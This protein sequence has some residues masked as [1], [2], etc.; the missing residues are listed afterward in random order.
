M[1]ATAT[2]AAW[3]WVEIAVVAAIMAGDYAGVVP[4]SSTP[5]LLLLAWLSLRLRR[6][7]WRDL[8]LAWPARRW[9]AIMAGAGAGVAIETFSLLVTVPLVTAWTGRPPDVSDF[10]SVTGNPGLL[11]LFLA[12]NWTL[13]A[14]GEEL[15]FRGYVLQRVADLGQRTPAAWGIALLVSSGLFGLGHGGQGV[16]GILQEAWAG[17]LLGALYLAAGRNLVVPI[18]AH[19]VS[20]TVA[21][22]LIYLG[23]YPGL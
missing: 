11:V 6:L 12:L 13:A 16:A 10:Q 23:R 9:R 18:V 20:N 1:A 14:F 4:I 8:G 21:F 2:H 15:A 7:R 5:F 19:G 22:I 17:L 3:G